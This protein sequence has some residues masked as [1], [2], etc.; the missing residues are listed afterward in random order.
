MEKERG[1]KIEHVEIFKG[2]SMDELLSRFEKCGSTAGN[3]GMAAR[4]YENM[5]RNDAKKFLALSGAIIPFGLRSLIADMIREGW[6][7]VLVTNGASIV[8]DLLEALGGS[9]YH[10]LSGKD[11][12]LRKNG[13]SRIW[14]VV[15]D[16]N[17]FS[18]LESHI[19]KAL[20]KFG[21]KLSISQFLNLLGK[22]IEDENSILGSAVRNNVPV[23]CPALPDSI[24]GLQTWMYKQESELHVDAFEDMKELIDICYRAKK[25][26]I[27]ILGGGVPKNFILQAMMMTPNEGFDYF[28]QI[29]LDRPESGSL[30]GAT[31]SEAISWKKLKKDADAVFVYCDVMVALPLI[32]GALKERLG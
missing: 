16:E 12:E 11:T 2:M 22:T 13:L 14:D 1:K 30:S 24:I 5:I 28:I 19:Q 9:H 26:G 32:V 6:V 18:T 15:V 20:K 23:F 25:S 7:D 4:I 17:D 10:Y 27:L 3:L 8:H 31:P 29:T 21:K